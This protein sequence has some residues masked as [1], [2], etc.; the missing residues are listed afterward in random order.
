MC[1]ELID[2][3]ST[4]LSKRCGVENAQLIPVNVSIIYGERRPNGTR[5]NEAAEE[6]KQ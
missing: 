4:Q 6:S 2:I 3:E 5:K 1:I